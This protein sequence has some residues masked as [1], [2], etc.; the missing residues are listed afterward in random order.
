MTDRPELDALRADLEFQTT[1][2]GES[3]SF[4][5]TWGLFSPREVDSGTRLLLD[6]IEVRPGDDCLDLGCGYGAIGVTLARLAPE[7]QTLLVDKDLVALDYARANVALNG[8]TNA[9]VLPS[10]GVT[11]VP[12]ER[13]FDL[14]ATNL[15]AKIGNEL[16]TLFIADAWARLRPGGRLYLVTLSGM[17]KFIQRIIQEQF[18]N[19][20]K[21]KQGRVHTIHRAVR[22]SD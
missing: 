10:N 15:P 12:E 13:R 19:Y 9:E 21:V 11:G 7:G 18:G 3:L 20:D 1:L 16:T 5:S 17:R 6:H 4:R 14:V 22:P 8:L 2:R